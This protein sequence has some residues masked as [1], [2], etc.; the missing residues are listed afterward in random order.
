TARIGFYPTNG[1]AGISNL[2]GV[3]A[4]N[5]KSGNH[6]TNRAPIW[7][8]WDPASPATNP[9][10]VKIGGVPQSKTVP[11]R[12]GAPWAGTAYALTIPSTRA[13]TNGIL[14]GYD[15]AAAI[16]NLPFTMEYLSVKLCRLFVHE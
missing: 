9:Q 6:G 16:A 10:P 11:A 7:S 13:G 15:V 8:L 4:F 14:D 5:F 12:F 1:T 2:I 3:W